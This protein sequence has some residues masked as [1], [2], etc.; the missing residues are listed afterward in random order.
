[1]KKILLLS[2]FF[3]VAFADELIN[4]YVEA[5]FTYISP[6]NGGTLDEIFV[7]KGQEIKVGDKLFSVGKEIN[8]ANLQIAINELEIAKLNYENLTKGKRD[9]E[10]TAIKEQLNSA[11]ITFENAKKEYNRALNL[12]N[13]GAISKSEFDLRKSN[14][15]NAK[16]KVSELKA[17]LQTANLG[18]RDDEIE[19]AKRNIKIAE[20]N[21]EKMQIQV[22]KN[23]AVSA[24]NGSIYDIF[25][26]KGEFVSQANPVLAIFEP[27]NL[28]VR[29]FVSQ[30]LLPSLKIGDEIAVIADGIKDEIKAKISFISPNAE[31]TPP[32]IYSVESREKMI[33]MIEAIPELNSALKAGLAVSVRIK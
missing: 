19:I 20:Q 2:L 29:F 27:Q 11:N 28:K 13:N 7:Q 32:V 24:T 15:E 12:Q 6:Y 18:A 5:E 3:F 33:F 21:L 25:F 16:A 26:R 1:M 8:E 9:S 22:S 14:F 17:I 31:F 4:G 23:T 10:I 30:K